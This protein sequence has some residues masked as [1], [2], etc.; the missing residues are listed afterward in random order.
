M[1][2]EGVEGKD[3]EF[4]GTEGPLTAYLSKPKE[5]GKHPGVIV[6]HEIWGLN[7]HIK[8]VAD[9]IASQ[10]YVALA[11]HLF[12]S[13]HVSPLLTESNIRAVM[14]FYR[15]VPPEKQRDTDFV[16]G[17]LQKLPEET[18]KVVGELRD[19]LFDLPEDKLTEELSLAV[20][21]LNSLDSVNGKIGGFGFCFGGSMSGL[22]ACTGKTDASVIFYGS[23][24]DPIDKVEKIKGAVMGIY[25]GMDKRI[26]SGLPELVKAMAEYEKPF[27]MCI[28]PGAP[29]AF[30]NDTSP[31][32]RE[33]AAKDAWERLLRFFTKN[34]R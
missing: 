14:D 25:G 8:D 10:G 27:E 6:I 18:R 22:L 4:R 12:S 33:A 32:Y 29:H 31:N 23:N 19:K 17:E 13:K 24:P 16:K 15:S 34:L 1:V 20:D 11:P 7:A 2:T 21:Y 5:G 3:I 9:R 26:N 30:F 28:Y